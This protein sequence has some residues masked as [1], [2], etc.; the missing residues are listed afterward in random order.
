MNDVNKRQYRFIIE[1][2]R[3]E[4]LADADHPKDHGEVGDAGPPALDHTVQ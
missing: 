3:K 4:Y 1:A 2:N